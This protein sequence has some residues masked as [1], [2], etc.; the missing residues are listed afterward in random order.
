[1][2][3]YEVRIRR[4]NKSGIKLKAFAT[5]IIDGVF[6]VDNFKVIEGSN[7]LFVSYPSHKGV[8]M[9]EG[10]QVEKYFDDVRFVG[11][12][13]KSVSDEVKAAI[14]AAYSGGSQ[15]TSYNTSR[16]DVAKAQAKP[17]APAAP[18]DTSE[19]ER[20]RKPLWGF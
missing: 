18:E 11:E 2:F 3:S 4:L 9:E 7:G 16:A 10:V 6:E 17:P 15:N 20:T 13:G 8:I 14:I 1:M 19:P 12:E 5:L